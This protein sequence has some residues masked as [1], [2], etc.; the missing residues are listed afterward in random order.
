MNSSVS[1]VRP[2]TLPQMFIYGLGE[3][4]Y[5]LVSNGFYGFAMLYYTEALDLS[6]IFAGLAM[7]VSMFWEAITEPVMGNVSDRTRSRFGRR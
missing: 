3:C 7:S 1:V 2:T 4:A 5:S 6:P